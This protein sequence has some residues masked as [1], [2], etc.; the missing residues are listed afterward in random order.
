[1]GTT[2]TRTLESLPY[3][4]NKYNKILTSTYTLSPQV[5]DFWNMITKQI[6]LEESESYIPH[7]S[8][9]QSNIVFSTKLFLFPWRPVFL[10]DQL[11]TNFHLPKSSLLMLVAACIWFEEMKKIY[12]HAIDQEYRFY[13][14]G[15]AMWLKNIQ[16]PTESI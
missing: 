13:S 6:S 7:V 5:C 1:V 15:D 12:A 10:I 9:D 11:I 14:F 8:L 3:L 16:A 4:W 2:V